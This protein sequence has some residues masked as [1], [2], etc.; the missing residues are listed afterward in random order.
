MKKSIC[1]ILIICFL[2][3][4]ICPISAG[5]ADSNDPAEWQDL[6][7][8]EEEKQAILANALDPADQI[9]TSGL[10]TTY[11]VAVSKS[12]N[13]LY[14]VGYTHCVSTVVKC[15]FTVFKIQRRPSSG[16]SWSTYANYTDLF[17]NSFQYDLSKQLSV[18]SGYE[19]RVT[20]THYAKKSFLS[21]ET[22][23]NTSN[24]VTI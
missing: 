5:A 7:L 21:T 6:E 16:G 2:F 15:G 14:V 11:S 4:A 10:I 13:T 3:S 18:S 1:A 22:I 24:T 12:G 20:C 23:N 8:S 19:Y 9:T 17:I